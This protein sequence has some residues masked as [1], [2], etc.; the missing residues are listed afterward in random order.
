LL[1]WRSAAFSVRSKTRGIGTAEKR[2][3]F[4]CLATADIHGSRSIGY[5]GLEADVSL[6]GFETNN[7]KMK[8][9]GQAW[10]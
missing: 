10:H 4:G 1:N 8:C 5:I 6:K 7:C 2:S 3:I 9:K